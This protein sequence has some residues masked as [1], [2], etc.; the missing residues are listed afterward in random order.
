MRIPIKGFSH[1][2]PYIQECDDDSR[3]AIRSGFCEL[4]RSISLGEREWE[5]TFNIFRGMDGHSG[6]DNICL[7]LEWAKILRGIYEAVQAA[8]ISAHAH[9]VDDGRNF[10]YSDFEVVNASRQTDE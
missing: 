5:D 3:T 9:G 8:T 1:A 2:L 10:G 6:W 7:P 4:V